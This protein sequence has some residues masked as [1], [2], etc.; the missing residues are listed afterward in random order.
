MK[1]IFNY[2]LILIL[3][4]NIPSSKVFA[5]DKEPIFDKSQIIIAKKYAERFCSAR[6]D[7]LF[8]GLDHER[9]LKY[10]Y[11]KYLG[12]QNEE[13]FSKDMYKPLIHQIKE[14]CLIKK[15]EESEI[16]EFFINPSNR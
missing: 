4:F 11:L 3:I 5:S 2:I 9:T 12:F 6:E 13:I 8:K 14:K 7:N 15:E 10:S 1:S 16:N